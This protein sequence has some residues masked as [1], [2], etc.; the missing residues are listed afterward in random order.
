[1]RNIINVTPVLL[2]SF[3][4]TSAL[5]LGPNGHRIVAK[6]AEDNLN[7]EAKAALM[8]ITN[9][10]PLAKLANW[11]D[12]IRSD[13]NWDFAKPWHYIS[14]DDDETFDGLAR[15][16]QGDILKALSHYE[17]QLRDNTLTRE[18]KWQALAFL[19]HFTGDIHQPLHVGRRD[20]RGGNDITVKWFGK[21][22]KLHAVWDTSMVEHQHLSYTEYADF[23]NNYTQDTVKSWQKSDY[24]D[25]AKDSKSLRENVYNLPQDM[26]I[27]YEYAYKNTPLLNKQ[28]SKAGVR[29]AGKLNNIFK[30]TD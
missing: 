21:E 20:D 19:I 25:W 2:I 16:K 3:L 7:P 27:G 13:K 10:D 28:M 12:E 1:M 24:Q 9:G 14:V 17:Q 15:S 22:S 11:P 26:N 23:L 6:I 8:Q 29:L 5:A 4:S 30:K 18:K